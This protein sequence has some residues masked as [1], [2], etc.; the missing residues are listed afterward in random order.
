MRSFGFAL[1]ILWFLMVSGCGLLRR[2]VKI[3]VKLNAPQ[4]PAATGEMQA[5]AA[6][7]DITPPPG[8]PMTGYGLFGRN[9]RGFWTRL[10][11]KAIYLED[12][13]G[14]RFVMVSC[15]LQS[16]PAVLA[17]RAAEI[18][19]KSTGLGREEMIFAATHTHLS[20]GNFFSGS[21]Y[22]AQASHQAGFDKT[23]FEFTAM[24]MALAIEKAVESKQPAEIRKVSTKVHGVS[25]NRSLGAFN[26]NREEEKKEILKQV[27]LG[28]ASSLYD[29]TFSQ[30]VTTPDVFR[31]I[32]PVLTVLSISPKIGVTPIAIAAFFAVHNT[33]M[34]METEVYSSD[35]FGVAEALT[36][37][38]LAKKYGTE[39]VVAIFNGAEGDASPNWEK[40]DRK[41]TVE[42][43]SKLAD[44]ILKAF[45]KA[46]QPIDGPIGY[47]YETVDIKSQE[48]K[49]LHGD[50]SDLCVP[51]GM[52]KTAKKPL[53]GIATLGG[54]EDGRT[55][56]Y[57]YG[58][59]E[60]VIADH[61]DSRQGRKEF[62]LE[63]VF[64]NVLNVDPDGLAGD[65]AIRITKGHLKSGT[66]KK[67]DLGVYTL[68]GNSGLAFVTLPGEFTVSLGARIKNSIGNVLGIPE[69]VLIGLA[70]EY[71][72]YFTTPLE[73][74]AQ[75]YE[76][77][78]TLYGQVAGLYVEG[79]LADL[80]AKKA[81][82]VNYKQDRCYKVGP[83]TPK[84]FGRVK[85]ADHWRLSEGLKTVL[86]DVKTGE[87][88]RDYPQ[89]KWVEPVFLLG[90][91]VG[92]SGE[93]NPV[94]KIQKETGGMWEDLQSDQGSLNFVSVIDSVVN[95]EAFWHTVWMYPSSLNSVDRFR[96]VV[97][98]TNGEP[99][100][101]E[102]FQVKQ[103][104]NSDPILEPG[105]CK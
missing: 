29:G 78:S 60:G 86:Q 103:H 98:T 39:T 37:S 35:L 10:Y 77:A 64:E 45:D 63:S 47:R 74:N 104:P 16:V 65:L 102:P 99:K 28:V 11:A 8:Y 95:G 89:F 85:E 7:V 80:A 81:G 50:A 38:D 40:Q 96:F 46:G 9:A 19:S 62:A 94:V 56:F 24:R 13:N 3:E 75:H 92:F 67:F 66:P 2:S 69:V 18:A 49:D 17:D 30:F 93:V 55:V 26:L 101:S 90:N 44:G 58:L 6:R 57:H 97:K 68:G 15:D 105:P 72:Q 36:E 71:L 83:K 14:N 27:P 51:N 1:L 43:A 82:T 21:V 73:Y 31:A 54:A 5:G 12:K 25:R 22:N 100:C 70:N 59:R 79:K 88:V 33:A 4:P 53:T 61:C 84:K 87:A 32:D 52:L 48:T 20:Q 41:N 76:G 23:L 91:D 34:G 42:I